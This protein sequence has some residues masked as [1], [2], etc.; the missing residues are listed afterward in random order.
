VDGELRK[1][2]FHIFDGISGRSSVAFINNRKFILTDTDKNQLVEVNLLDNYNKLNKTTSILKIPTILNKPRCVAVSNNNLYIIDNGRILKYNLTSKTV[3]EYN[4]SAFEGENIG[5][6]VSKSE[7]ICVSNGNK[8]YNVNIDKKSLSEINIKCDDC[9]GISRNIAFDGENT[10]C[11]A[12]EKNKKVLLIDF[13]TGD[14]ICPYSTAEDGPISIAED[15]PISIACANNKIFLCLA[16]K[17]ILK[18][19]D[20]PR[21]GKKEDKPKVN[22]QKLPNYNI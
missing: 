10:I 15:G 3:S 13:S 5:L 2:N 4:N 17:N 20:K 11:I 9:V 16:N 6:A 19:C 12:D 18:V 22:P 1:N 21:V 7:N 8:I 14:V